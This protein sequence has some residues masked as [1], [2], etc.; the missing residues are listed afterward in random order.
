MGIGERQALDYSFDSYEGDIEN[1]VFYSTN[2]N[3]IKIEN[4]NIFA[5]GKGRAKVVATYGDMASEIVVIVADNSYVLGHLNFDGI[6]NANDS[7]VA[8]DIYKYGIFDDTQ[9]LIGDINFD[10][11]VNAN[12]AALILDIYKYG[13]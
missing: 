13:N 3:V 7:A 9:I 6:V 4:G 1:I 11:V 5:V 8:L 2:T 12:D 10:N